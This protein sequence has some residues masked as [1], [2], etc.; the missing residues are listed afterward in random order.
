[1]SK[2]WSSLPDLI[3]ELLCG[4]PARACQEISTSPSPHLRLNPLLDFTGPNCIPV[5]PQLFL[6]NTFNY[7]GSTDTHL[8]G[9]RHKYC[10]SITIQNGPYQD[11]NASACVWCPE[12]QTP[13]SDIISCVLW[14]QNKACETDAGSVRILFALCCSKHILITP[15]EMFYI[16]LHF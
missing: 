6:S 15:Q 16:N 3:A 5:G 7:R 11:P 9:H 8:S 14:L 13:S 12:L 10:Y 4:I 1:M 2:L